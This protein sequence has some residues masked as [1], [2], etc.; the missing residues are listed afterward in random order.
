MTTRLVEVIESCVTLDEVKLDLRVDGSEDDSGIE[1]MIES[2][3]LSAGS[4][5]NRAAALCQWELLL[6]AFP[7]SAIR[8]LHPPV[9]RIISVKYRDQNG[10]LQTLSEY[11]IDATVEPNLLTGEWPHEATDVRVIYQSGWGESA[12]APVKQW[13][14]LQV[15]HFYRNREAA[16]EKSMGPLAFLDALLHP[17][18]LWEI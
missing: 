5:M 9:R 10:D 15:G 6:P 8:L 3:S 4:V 18:K 7:N 13:I 2:A 11:S 1:R 12:P 14:R 17:Y 16:T